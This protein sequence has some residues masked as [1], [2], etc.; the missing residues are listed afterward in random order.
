MTRNEQIKLYEE[1]EKLV[2]FVISRYYPTFLNNE[3]L[4]QIGKLG[5][6]KAC[7]SYKDSKGKFSTYGCRLIR[8]EINVHF[9]TSIRKKR[10]PVNQITSVSYRIDED[11]AHGELGDLCLEAGRTS[12]WCGGSL[13]ELLTERQMRILSYMIKGLT[14]REIGEKLGVSHSAIHFEKKKIE[15]IIDENFIDI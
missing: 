9:R 5:L 3:D 14:Q 11:K 8:N 4:R 13:K 1:N 7:L 10:I 15:K 6:W 2:S 12:I